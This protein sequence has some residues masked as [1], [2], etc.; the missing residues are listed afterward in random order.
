MLP[1]RPGER[2]SAHARPGGRAWSVT[3]VRPRRSAPPHV[4]PPRGR[5]FQGAELFGDGVGGRG[6]EKHGITALDC[7]HA[8]SAR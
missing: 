3:P 7:S 5:G 8:G 2:L 4:D 6:S 1:A